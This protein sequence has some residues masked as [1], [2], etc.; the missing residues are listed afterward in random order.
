ME[1]DDIEDPKEFKY[2]HL[3]IISK[4]T[5]PVDLVPK[6]NS[7]PEINDRLFYR[8]EDSVFVE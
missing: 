1:Q 4:F 2:T 6:D 3:L 7:I 8:W 5:V